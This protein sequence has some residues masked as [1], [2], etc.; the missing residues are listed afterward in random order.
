MIIEGPV[1]EASQVVGWH[2]NGIHKEAEAL[3]RH[4]SSFG[5]NSSI[6]WDPE[7]WGRL[8]SAEATK[9][10][11]TLLSCTPPSTYLVIHIFILTPDKFGLIRDMTHIRGELTAYKPD[12]VSS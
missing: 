11:I 12:E 9:Q 6:L 1:C 5:F 4:T 2:L 7:R 3:A 10:V 8:P